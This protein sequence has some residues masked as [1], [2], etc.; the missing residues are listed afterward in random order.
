MTTPY[1]AKHYEGDF[2]LRRI[3]DDGSKTAI[4]DRPLELSIAVLTFEE[5]EVRTLTSKGRDRYGATVYSAQDPGQPRIEI[6]AMEA[7]DDIEAL[8]FAGVLTRTTVTGGAVAT[9]AVE[10]PDIGNIVKLAHGHIA[11]SPAPVITSVNESSETTTY[12][13]TTDYE[14]DRT[15]GVLRIREGST[16]VA[17]TA[18]NAA[19]THTGYTRTHIGGGTKP[20]QHFEIAGYLKNRPDNVDS[21]M[22]IYD[23]NLSRADNV[24]LLG[25]EPLAIAMAGPLIVPPGKSYPYEIE[26]REAVEA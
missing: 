7:P 10:A 26:R 2:Y 24:S 22:T 11:A 8:M 16:I 23:A 9:E 18:L 20:T 13:A 19:Y 3:N 1:K 5:G 15:F 4:L 6:T 25:D 17:G 12:S 21:F 14:L